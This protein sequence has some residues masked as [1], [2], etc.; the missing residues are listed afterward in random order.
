M[1]PKGMLSAAI[2]IIHS[3]SVP[4][5]QLDVKLATQVGRPYDPATVERDVRYLWSLGRFDDIR[6][7]EPEPG[8]LV[9]RVRPRPH[10]LL[11]DIRVEPHSFGLELKIPPGTPIDPVSARA[12][13]RGVEHQLHARVT[14]TLIP[15][16]QGEV[17]LK[18]RVA[19]PGK[20]PRG[21]PSDE[22]HYQISKD[23]CRT[24]ILERSDAERDGVLDFA[25]HFDFDAGLRIERGRQYRVGRIDFLGHR[26]YSDSLVRRLVL[27]DEGAIFDERL[28]RL[29]IARLNRT[30]IFDPVDPRNVLVSR[31]AASGIADVTV[32]LAERKRGSWSLSGPWPLQGAVN[33]RIPKWATYAVS[34][35]VFGSSLKLLNLP[36]RFT[37]VLAMQRPFTPGA[38]WKSGFTI[39]PQI[40]WR[41]NGIAYAITQT[42]HRLLPRISGEQSAQPVLAVT[43]DTAMSCELK[44]RLKLVRTAATVALQLMGTL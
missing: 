36:R 31:D 24:L 4:G 17:D 9:F 20:T 12:I 11:R 37:P 22:I 10:L 33:A 21:A 1:H 27:L 2:L 25:A 6:V 14:E 42:Q 28:L 43:G 15:R 16:R 29:S 39:A 3:V 18:L 40:G 19:P 23:L 38:G 13:A 26:H 44:P 7:E 8:D 34:L 41:G 35:S 5:T 32:R 30:G